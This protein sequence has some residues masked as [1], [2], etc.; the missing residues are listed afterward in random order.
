[1][2]PIMMHSICSGVTSKPVAQLIS[3]LEPPVNAST[4]AKVAEPKMTRKAITVT[5]SAP[6]SDL[7]NACPRHLA[8]A[9]GEHDHRHRAERRRLGRR[10]PADQHDQHREHDDRHHRDDVDEDQAQLLAARGVV[11]GVGRRRAGVDRHPGPDQHAVHEGED[12]AGD[13]AGDEQRADVG[14]AERRQQHGQRRGRNDHRQ[15]AHAHDRA[16]RQVLAVAAPDHLRRHQPAEQ[17]AGAHRRAGRAGVRGAADQR[18]VGEAPAHVAEQLVGGVE[19]APGEAGV[20]EQLAH[21]QEHRDRHQ[22]EV[23]HRAEA[24]VDHLLDAG[25]AAHEERRGDDVG[26]EEAD[27]HRHAEHHQPE[28]RAEQQRRDPVPGHRG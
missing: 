6:S 3:P 23:G 9:G 18:D 20:I 27:R 1:M 15:A 12:E 17:R 22:R 19:A 21:Q 2:T 4:W 28:G 8:V 5:R 24:V 7:L 14:A 11:G 10:A 13:D 16:D 26:D 25:A